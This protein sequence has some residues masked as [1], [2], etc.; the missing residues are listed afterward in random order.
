MIPVKK[1]GLGLLN[2]LTSA[3]E[4]YLISQRGSVE[5]VWAVTG[6]GAFYNADHV[7]TLSEERHDG[8]KYRDAAYETKLKVLVSNLK[9]TDKTLLIHAIT[10]HL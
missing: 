8:K 4:K 7:Q 2:P 6:G 9:V 10:V 1:S 5:L 3:Q